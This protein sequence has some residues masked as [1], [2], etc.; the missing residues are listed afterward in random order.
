MDPAALRRLV[1]EI[2]AQ[3]LR[4][5]EAGK[6]VPA[7]P[8]PLVLMTGADL[9][10]TVILHQ[11]NRIETACG[12]C[13]AALSPTFGERL[14]P[15]EFTRETGIAEVCVDL[16]REQIVTLVARASLLLVGTL[17][18]SSRAKMAAGI[19]DSMPSRIW[20]AARAAG[21]PLFIADPLDPLVIPSAPSAPPTRVQQREEAMATLRGDGAVVIRACEVAER[22]ERFLLE[23]ADP[24]AAKRQREAGPRPIVTVEDVE[25]A[26]RRGVKEWTLPSEAI[27]TMAAWDRARDL[28]LDLRG[29]N[30]P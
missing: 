16:A 1:E 25:R 7:E 6:G 4:E 14:A 2:A 26:H 17:S 15:E 22:V 8:R 12:P 21:V 9:D 23:R 19:A 11:L 10:V 20:A 5:R 27:V 24:A 18:D 13:V 3:V 28:G 30:I 29:G